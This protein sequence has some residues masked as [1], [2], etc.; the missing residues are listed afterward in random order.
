MKRNALM[1]FAL[2]ILAFALASTIPVG[3]QQAT[4]F[5]STEDTTLVVRRM[6]EGLRPDSWGA[7]ASPD[8]RYLTQTDWGTGDLA[9]LDLLT[10][11]SRH[12]TAKPSGWSEDSYSESAQFS[13]DGKAIAYAWYSDG[14]YDVRI[15]GI[16]GSGERIVVPHEPDG[17]R[18]HF[19]HDWSLDGGHLLVES[20]V[21]RETGGDSCDLRLVDVENGATQVLYVP[22]RGHGDIVAGFSPD[23]RYAG[24]SMISREKSDG[25]AKD[26]DLYVLSLDGGHEVRVLAGPQ[27]DG[28]VGWSPS[29]NDIL[30]TSDRDLT[31]GVWQLS[32]QD[33]RAAGEPVLVKGDL[34][35]IQSIG[36]SGERL[37]YG[38]T[39]DRKTL[40][41]AGI[42]LG[43]GRLTSQPVRVE[44]EPELLVGPGAWSPDG[45]MLAYSRAPRGSVEMFHTR[46]RALWW[47]ADRDRLIAHVTATNDPN[48][49]GLLQID[50]RT[51]KTSRYL[52]SEGVVRWAALTADRKTA[53]Y[54]EWN[55]PSPVPAHH[56][57]RHD[58]LTGK[59]EIVAR[60]D[61][62]LTGL[63]IMRFTE[64]SP[65]EQSL[66]FQS[67]NR[68]T[69][70][71]T[72]GIISTVTGE[73][74]ELARHPV[75]V[76]DSKDPDDPD[77]TCHL[78]N[79]TADGQSIVYARAITGQ[80]DCTIYRVPADGGDVESLG[81]MPS[82]VAA[83][84]T[85]DQSR[86]VFGH[87]ELR[88]EIWMMDNIQW[89][90]DR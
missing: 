50:L 86:V 64:L 45:L 73:A 14:D 44:T 28:F 68:E 65:D 39:T 89:S 78:I 20:C 34:W 24:F 37:F 62:L 11:E 4:G 61:T 9:V 43:R 38:I 30:F 88:G 70:E 80:R 46:H 47:G 22:P 52:K 87:G 3:P 12:V 26:G 58:L 6:Y 55:N 66:A 51:G 21:L 7:D 82:H 33:G 41:T 56:L 27:N 13:P 79:W 53:Y 71:W 76:S 25:S 54:A 17:R 42:D 60:L 85:P 48:W 67:F 8:G 77:V 81:K 74:R 90:S 10:G 32:I 84:L 36:I 63:M 57:K 5:T 72:I 2:A 29:G 49:N 15:I 16:D 1:F 40:Y 19:L 23:G 35:N 69:E 75:Q 83:F 18:W 59:V 31:E